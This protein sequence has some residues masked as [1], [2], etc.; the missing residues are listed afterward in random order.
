MHIK[1]ALIYNH[2]LNKLDL[3]K[4]YPLIQDGEKIKYLLLQ[5]PNALQ[6]NVIAFMG[7]LPKEFDLHNKINMDLQ[8]EKSFV[9]PLEF[10][11]EAIDWRH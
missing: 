8:F 1:G 4:K 3:T 10:I 5:T 7:E 2:L 6:T 11:V 9:D